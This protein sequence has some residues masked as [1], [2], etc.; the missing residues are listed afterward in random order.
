M[1]SGSSSLARRVN[2]HQPEYAE[3]AGVFIVPMVCRALIAAH[4]LF[5]GVVAVGQETSAMQ[6]LPRQ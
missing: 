1:T 5:A 2:L 4:F 3:V 6:D